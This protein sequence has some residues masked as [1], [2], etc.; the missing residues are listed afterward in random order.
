LAED[1]RGKIEHILGTQ[2]QN[3][4]EVY[5]RIEKNFVAKRKKRKQNEKLMAVIDPMQNAKR[6]LKI[7]AKHR[8]NKKRKIMTFKT[9]RC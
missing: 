8:A 2:N 7:S 1:T 6:K 9:G 5:H 4:V 3:F